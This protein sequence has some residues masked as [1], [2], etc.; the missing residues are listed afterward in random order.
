MINQF[1][2]GNSDALRSLGVAGQRPGGEGLVFLV[3]AERPDAGTEEAN[4]KKLKGEKLCFSLLGFWFWQSEVKDF[5]PFKE[6][7]VQS[8]AAVTK[9]L[10]QAN[11]FG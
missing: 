8:G 6:R 4:E 1:A 5:R 2:E 10:S 7:F 9:I 3:A 11:E